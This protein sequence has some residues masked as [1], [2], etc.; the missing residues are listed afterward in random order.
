MDKVL[1]E[2]YYNAEDP[3]SYGGVEKLFR[4]AKKAGVQKVTRGRV[5]QFLADQQSYSLHK[6]ARRHF[7]RNPTCVKAIDGQWQADLADMQA[8]S[9][10]NKRHKFIMTVIDI[11]CKRAWAIPIKNKTGKEMLTAFQQ[12][13]KDAHPTKPARL[14]TDSG[15][16]FLNKDF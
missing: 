4:S 11:L 14:Q 13:F 7:E 2:L 8:L 1:K 6:P 10:D 5:T 3:G 9:R 16:E 12:L 15:K